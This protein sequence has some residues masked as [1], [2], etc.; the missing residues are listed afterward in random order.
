MPGRVNESKWEEAKKIVEKEYGPE[1]KIGNDKFYSLTSTIYQKMGG[2]FE[3]EKTS[4]RLSLYAGVVKEAEKLTTTG[5]AHIKDKNFVYPPSK[6]N[7]EGKYP[8]QDIEHARNALARVAASGTG[9]EKAE[10]KKEV[11]DKYPSLEKNMEGKK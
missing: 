3:K 7:P 6:E 4:S 2:T 1:S 10:V 5:R 11:G 9:T 8:I